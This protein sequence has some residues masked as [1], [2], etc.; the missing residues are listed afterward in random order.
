MIST[1]PFI[2]DLSEKTMEE[3]GDT[4][5]N[6]GNKVMFYSRM[7]NQAMV[8]QIMMVQ[9]SYRQEYRKRQDELWAKKDQKQ[10]KINIQ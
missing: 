6:L 9:E 7:G 8:N 10:P 5:A 2:N 3:L 4:I 1:H